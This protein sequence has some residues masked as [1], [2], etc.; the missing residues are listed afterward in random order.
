MP[1]Y[2]THTE[3]RTRGGFSENLDVTTAS[4]TGA[5]AEAD[6]IIDS[7]IHP[8]YALPLSETPSTIKSIAVR[9][10]L[11]ILLCDEYGE[12]AQ[13]TNKEGMR[14]KKWA[15]DKLKQIVSGELTLLNSSTPREELTR[16]TVALPEFYPTD[17]SSDTSSTDNNTAA[18]IAIN[19]IF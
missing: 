19:D 6:D 11:G 13:D 5:I 10:S 2:C 8:V 17:T 1:N 12:E 9:L 18:R 4:I 7:Y 3:V 14:H 16:S 15:E